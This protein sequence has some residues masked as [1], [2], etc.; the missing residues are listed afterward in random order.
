MNKL[1]KVMMREKGKWKVLIK[2][3][4]R[5]LVAR[6]NVTLDEEHSSILGHRVKKKG[7]SKLDF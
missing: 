6:R 3:H 5:H 7:G 2:W 4:V 1:K